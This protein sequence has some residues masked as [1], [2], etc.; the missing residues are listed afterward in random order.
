MANPLVLAATYNKR[1]IHVMGG[2]RIDPDKLTREL[3]LIE[4]ALK[5]ATSFVGTVFNVLDYGADPRGVRDAA[6]ALQG[7]LDAMPDGGTLVVPDGSFRIDSVV[8]ITYA[9]TRIVGTGTLVANLTTT[10]DPLLYAQGVDGFWCDGLTLTGPFS[11]GFLISGGDGHRIT[12]NEVSGGT[13]RDSSGSKG[14]G[15]FIENSTGSVVAYNH[16]HD[17]GDGASAAYYDILGDYG[18]YQLIDCTFEG[19]RCL[20]SVDSNIGLFDVRRCV[21]R[22]NTARNAITP[23]SP[24]TAGGYGIMIYKNVGIAAADAYGNVIAD[25]V[26]EDTGGTGIYVQSMQDTAVTGNT[27]KSTC[28]VQLDTSLTVA[29]IAIHESPSCAVAGNVIDGSGMAGIGVTNDESAFTA[30]TGNIVKNCTRLGINLRGDLADVAV[31]GNTVTECARDGIGAHADTALTRINVSGNVVRPNNSGGY[32]G[33]YLPANTVDCSVTD[34]V[35]SDTDGDAIVATGSGAIVRDNQ[36]WDQI[37]TVTT[38][39]AAETKYQTILGDA[40]GG[41]FDVDLPAAAS[42]PGRVYTVKKIDAGANA[43]TVDGNGAETIDGAATFPL[44]AQWDSVTIQS[45]GS[46]WYVLATV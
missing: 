26:V 31:V 18:T 46:A 10:T 27:V 8:R 6:P 21:I 38:T 28:Q 12:R 43:V 11:W 45:N 14:G 7:A 29:G 44:A 42:C 32:R 9:N 16:F 23:A 30:V 20:S 22:G 37:G 25:N 3:G 1:P 33:I 4:G 2:D 39:H 5:F 40:T 41:A 34:N 17:N 15:L 35:V 19:N 24:G 36:G 13:R